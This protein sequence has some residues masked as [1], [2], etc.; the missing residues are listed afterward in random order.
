MTC[1]CGHDEDDHTELDGCT[2]KGC[3]C[4]AFEEGDG[5]DDDLDLHNDELYL[6]D[7]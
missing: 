7:E 6:D 2:V 3:D 5:E 4:I 1:T